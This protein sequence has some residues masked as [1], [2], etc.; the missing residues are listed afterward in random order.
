[1][2]PNECPAC[3]SDRLIK[4]GLDTKKRTRYSCNICSKT[5]TAETWDKTKTQPQRLGQAVLAVLGGMGIGT[6]S[7]KYQVSAANILRKLQ[8]EKPIAV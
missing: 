7:K 6:A 1:M 2:S 3:G 5:W 8:E 4:R